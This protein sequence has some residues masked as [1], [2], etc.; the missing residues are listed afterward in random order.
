[1][2]V[3]GRKRE[4]RERKEKGGKKN[5]MGKWLELLRLFKNR[6]RNFIIHTWTT[7]GMEKPL[8][9]Y[10]HMPSTAGPVREIIRKMLTKQSRDDFPCQHVSAS[11]RQNPGHQSRKGGPQSC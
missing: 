1:M 10:A 2:G 5:L 7:E 3:K 4:L 8:P 6:A 9:V 11:E